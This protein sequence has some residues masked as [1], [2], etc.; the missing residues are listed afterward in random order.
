[1]PN[2]S[3]FRYLVFGLTFEFCK[4]LGVYLYVKARNKK[5][6]QTNKNLLNVLA[7][8]NVAMCHVF[9]QVVTEMPPHVQLL[10]DFSFDNANSKVNTQDD[11]EK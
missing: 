7:S 5:M 9:L 3:P 10:L 8:M 6:H 1:V 4:E 2:S 11:N